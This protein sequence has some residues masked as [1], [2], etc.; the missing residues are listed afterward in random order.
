MRWGRRGYTIAGGAKGTDSPAT[1]ES[2]Q[3]ARAS[4]DPFSLSGALR[5]VWVW[6]VVVVFVLGSR[7]EWTLACSPHLLFFLLFY[8]FLF[9]GTDRPRAHLSS[10]HHITYPCVGP[11]RI[12][13]WAALSSIGP[14]QYNPLIS[15][16]GGGLML[17]TIRVWEYPNFKSKV[18]SSN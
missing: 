3:S 4:M 16:H 7:V 15:A 8:Y 18:H 12:F 5:L 6:E 2:K 13:S 14:P 17:H 9:G 10:T 11:H 1:K